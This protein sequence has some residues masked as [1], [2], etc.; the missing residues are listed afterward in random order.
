MTSPGGT[1]PAYPATSVSFTNGVST[2]PLSVTLYDA[3]RTRSPLQPRHPRS[4]ARAR[5]RV[6]N[7]SHRLH[8]ANPGPQTAGTAFSET[9]T[10][11][12]P[13]GNV[14]TGYTGNQAITFSGPPNSPNG[15]AP[16]YPH[17]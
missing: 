11:H 8:V 17:T 15:T 16:I 1:A 14:A 3:V 6:A 9:I 2:T 5:S 10:A 12:D 7:R 4:A 13:Y